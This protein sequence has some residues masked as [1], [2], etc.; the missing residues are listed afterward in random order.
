[1]RRRRS[2]VTIATSI[3]ELKAR[4]AALFQ[5][6]E[7]EPTSSWLRMAE[8]L[9]V[10]FEVVPSGALECVD[11]VRSRY[12]A[13]CDGK[14]NVRGHWNSFKTAQTLTLRVEPRLFITDPVAAGPFR[15]VYHAEKELLELLG[16]PERDKPYSVGRDSNVVP[17]PP[18]ASDVS[19]HHAS[20]TWSGEWTLRDEGSTHGT[21]INGRRIA[22]QVEHVVRTGDR[23]GL[24]NT[25]LAT[26]DLAR[27]DETDLPFV[28]ELGTLS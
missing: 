14:I 24:G 17:I 22:A 23:I 6:G 4:N 5:R 13:R 26:L 25:I 3:D 1:M 8:T 10:A 2:Q 16:T 9:E 19:R 11:P 20:L 28:G 18:F 7:V 27:V 12:V 21:F 15:G